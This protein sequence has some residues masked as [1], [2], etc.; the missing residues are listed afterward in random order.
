MRTTATPPGAREIFR[1]RVQRQRDGQV[2]A[3][4]DSPACLSR[5]SDEKQALEK[6]RNE[7]RYRIEWCPCTGVDDDYV[8]LEIER[9]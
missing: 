6:I 5:A 9:G 8:Q 7:I 1:V 2:L 4:C 3:T